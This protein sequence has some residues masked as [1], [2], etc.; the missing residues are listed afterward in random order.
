M[1]KIYSV[2]LVVLLT[3]AI[4]SCGNKNDAQSKPDSNTADYGDAITTQ[5]ADTSKM[6]FDFTDRDLSGNYNES[7]CTKITL[8][9]G[10]DV[11]ITKS[12]DYIISGNS[13]DTM[14]S[15]NVGAED[16]VQIVLKD[17]IFA[18]KDG[19]A[20][21]IK[22]ADKVFIT[23]AEN[24]NNSIC[25]AS[26]YDVTDDDTAIDAAIFSKEDLTLNGKGTLKVN[27]NY[28]HGIVSKD[29]LVIV[30]LTL[31]V[32]AKSS[33]LCGK[34][35]VKVS[36]ADI[37]VDAGSDGMKSDNA[38]DNNRGF[39][40][41]NNGTFNITSQNDAFQAQTVL[42]ID[43]GDVKVISGGGSA[44]SSTIVGGGENPDWRYGGGGRPGVQ[45]SSSMQNAESAKGLKAA[46]DILISSGNFSL[47]CADDCVHSNGTIDISGGNFSIS[48]G[49]DGVHADS[50]LII[51]N[52]TINIFKSYEG[53]ES[54]EMLIS[55]GTINLTA[56]DDGLNAAGGNDAS[57]Q[58][59]RP[60]ANSFSADASK[61]ITISGG[62]V[63][64]DASGD[65][66]D[67]NG[68]INVTGGTTIV[69]GPTNSG[70]ASFDYDGR[71]TVTGGVLLALG[72][73][74][75]AQGF[76]DSQNQG[77]ILYNITSQSSGTS[78][79]LCD[80]NGMAIV[81]FIPQKVYSSVTVTAPE[82][83]NGSTY[84]LVV[85]A[86]VT[87]ADKNGFA[88]NTNISGGETIATIKMTS[89]LYSTGGQGM[90][91]GHGGGGMM[92]PGRP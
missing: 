68:V 38:E 84:T 52:G 51:S 3:V 40:Y 55:G 45:Q 12:G 53:L 8:T 63:F 28:K 23:A 66:I 41:I 49:D 10:K 57:S 42:K 37:T 73:S 67:S 27:G 92:R 43:G 20:I 24:T 82:I 61:Q 18:N 77:A 2:I 22:Q 31:N 79:S 89:N 34:D 81:A 75:M 64:I 4:C 32:T 56:S 80:E 59:G 87:N 48:S 29:D 62:Y 15:V 13:N 58:G 9:N 50:A 33:G 46:S 88:R 47:N 17:A 1:K 19:P 7:E 91:G 65:G 16:K 86:I 35:C 36:S 30:N 85:G 21:L 5:K 70:N 90:G 69:S 83:K 44:N 76:T 74:G 60:G 26:S 6:E 71:A 25:D 54:G 72:S 39:I 78:L 14:I 11:N